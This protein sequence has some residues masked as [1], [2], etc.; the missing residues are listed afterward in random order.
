MHPDMP[1]TSSFKRRGSITAK[2]LHDAFFLAW[3]KPLL[4]MFPKAENDPDKWLESQMA[5]FLGTKSD[6]APNYDHLHPLVVARHL[7]EH[8]SNLTYMI[9]FVGSYKWVRETWAIL[10]RFGLPLA[11]VDPFCEGIRKALKHN[12]PIHYGGVL[13]L[14]DRIR[15]DYPH[16]DLRAKIP[17]MCLNTMVIP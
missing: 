9:R 7:R 3:P 6:K 11:A 14:T 13:G 5:L 2:L 8:P 16:I 12:S 1:G 10:H 15:L 4:F 17:A